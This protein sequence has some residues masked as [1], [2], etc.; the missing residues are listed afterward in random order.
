MKKLMTSLLFVVATLVPTS[1][2]AFSDVEKN[3]Y[4][5]T[6]INWAAEKKIIS[7]YAD[8]TFKPKAQVTFDQFIKMYANSF[9]FE[10]KGATTYAEFYDVLR[11][12]NIEF[13]YKNKYITRGD[14]AV[15]F[16]YATGS[17]DADLSSQPLHMYYEEAAQFM[18]DTQLSTGQQT[19]KTAAE[20]FGAYNALTRGQVV[21]FLYRANELQLLTIADNIRYISEIPLF[22]A[23]DRIIRS[24]EMTDD[25][26]YYV[27]AHENPVANYEV[28]IVLDN[29]VIGGYYAVPQTTFLGYDIGAPFEENV[30]TPTYYNVTPHI[31]RFAENEV[32]AVSY[33]HIRS[34]KEQ[35]LQDALNITLYSNDEAI[36]QLYS[37]LANEFRAKNDKSVLQ[38]HATLT[39]AS[40]L[41]SIDMAK[42][43]YFSHTSLDGSEPWD[44]IDLI[45]PSN[46]FMMMGE[47]IAAGYPTIFDAH[48][49]WINSPGHRQNLLAFHYEY[50][51]FGAA[52]QS[53]NE[54]Y[55]YYTTNFASQ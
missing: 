15:L 23:H 39:S 8:D 46:T 43:N 41:H 33:R 34:K 40:K 10:T 53:N 37:D 31:D 38:P 27:L 21:T 44:R 6:P 20:R 28:Q 17:L 5:A 9:S 2:Y 52:S 49:G 19:G 22:T 12:Y 32:R 48:T 55:P 16:A 14:V 54:L 13:L 30:I 29:E 50:I 11:Q 1:V 7:G 42:N 24:Y 45:S 25:V 35:R 36:S 18:L 47:N 51:G 4:Y 26:T 3:M